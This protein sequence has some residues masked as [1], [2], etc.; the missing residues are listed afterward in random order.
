MKTIMIILVT[1]IVY[2]MIPSILNYIGELI[3]YHNKCKFYYEQY[4]N[5]LADYEDYHC[6]MERCE[7]KHQAKVINAMIDRGKQMRKEFFHS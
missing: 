4:L 7:R 2:C 6:F 3:R 1:L 5:R